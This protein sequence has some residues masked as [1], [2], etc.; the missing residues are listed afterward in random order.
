LAEGELRPS[1]TIAVIRR[2][3]MFIILTW[4]DFP[5]VSLVL[6]EDG[7]VRV[8]ETHAEAQNFAE[9]EL[10]FNWKIVEL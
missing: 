7:L 4:L 6:N 5:D 8:F 10:S 1:A 2:R 3:E 9:S